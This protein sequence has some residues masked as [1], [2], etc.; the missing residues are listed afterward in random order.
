M[1]CKRFRKMIGNFE[2]KRPTINLPR[3]QS[4]T[5]AYGRW[6]SIFLTLNNFSFA[7]Q[8]LFQSES[9]WR[10][11]IENEQIFP[12]HGSK[13]S[14]NQTEEDIY[15]VDGH[16]QTILLRRG[17][18]RWEIRFAFNLTYHNLLANYAQQDLKILFLDINNNTWG[19]SV[20]S[21]VEGF[22]TS[23]IDVKKLILGQSETPTWTSVFVELLD[24][25]QLND[26]VTIEQSFDASDLRFIPV[27]TQNES[28]TI[29]T[30]IFF[31]V[32]DSQFSIPVS[33][34]TE[35][36]ISI[37]DTVSGP[38]TFTGFNSLGN[39]NYS[40]TSLSSFI[41]GDITID[42]GIYKG[43]GTYNFATGQY[44]PTQYNPAQYKTT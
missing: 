15:E 22:E 38:I 37:N 44:N 43:S 12:I 39:G 36:D 32:I 24:S 33:T 11:A 41:Q 9:A 28:Q 17:K 2:P 34:L 18:Y 27:I 7:S 21:T 35:A 8:A 20:E 26:A 14:E 29:L 31:Q 6:V 10:T 16:D 23:L 30:D 1:H 3:C 19:R 13:E 4:T 25:N 42:S 40:I 5:K